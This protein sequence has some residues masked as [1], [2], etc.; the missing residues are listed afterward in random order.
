MQKLFKLDLSQY[1][2]SCSSVK[3]KEGKEG[4]LIGQDNL[5]EKFKNLKSKPKKAP[6]K[7]SRLYILTGK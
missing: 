7:R 2:V 4:I 6:L 3:R 1:Q 5:G